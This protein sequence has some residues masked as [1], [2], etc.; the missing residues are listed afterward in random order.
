MDVF[1]DYLKI[2]FEI[3]ALSA[4]RNPSGAVPTGPRAT[5]QAL[6]S[7]HTLFLQQICQQAFLYTPKNPPLWCHK[8]QPENLHEMR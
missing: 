4:K 3:F 8:Q 5:P 1:Y 6:S 2:Y 7:C